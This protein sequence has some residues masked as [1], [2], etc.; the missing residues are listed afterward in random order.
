MKIL[1]VYLSFVA[2]VVGWGVH[3]ILLLE[4]TTYR[5]I[6]YDEMQVECSHKWKPGQERSGLFYKYWVPWGTDLTKT[7]HIRED[8]HTVTLYSEF[9]PGACFRV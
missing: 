7:V 1:V 6:V 5:S 9:E 4:S 3:N 2:C 8:G